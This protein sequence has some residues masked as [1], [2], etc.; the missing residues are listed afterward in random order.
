MP[1]MT[2]EQRFERI[3]RTLEWIT[4]NQARFMTDFER[5]K[6]EFAARFAQMEEKHAR[7]YARARQ[8]T[9]A[10]LRGIRRN[11]ARLERHLRDE[12]DR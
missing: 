12:H 4:E 1:E 9:L 8:I 2:P 5:S 6:A 3:E 11:E 10:L 7:A